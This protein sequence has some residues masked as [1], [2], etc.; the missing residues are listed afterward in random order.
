MVDRYIVLLR[1]SPPPTADVGSTVSYDQFQTG[2]SLKCWPSWTDEVQMLHII[3]TEPFKDP[4]ILLSS[5]ERC[6]K[7]KFTRPSSPSPHTGASLHFL[8][9][10]A[11]LL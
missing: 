2:L 6:S 9:M 5:S 1:Y 4:A 8:L 10:T 7:L 3:S 11:Q